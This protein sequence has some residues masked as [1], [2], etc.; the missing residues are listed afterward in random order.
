MKKNLVRHCYS[1]PYSKTHPNKIFRKFLQV[2]NLDLRQVKAKLVASTS[3][4][5]SPTDLEA[6]RKQ[7]EIFASQENEM[8]DRKKI[9]R[10][11]EIGRTL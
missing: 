2:K 7:T 9:V 6:K 10:T 8:Q 5:T 1:S 4:K 11:T 3:S